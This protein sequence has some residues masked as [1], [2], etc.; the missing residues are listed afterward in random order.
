MTVILATR[1]ATTTAAARSTLVAPSLRS[2]GAT[3]PSKSRQEAWGDEYGRNLPDQYI[4]ITGLTF[5]RYR[6]IP[7]VDASDWFLESNEANNV[8]WI[9]IQLKGE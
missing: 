4:D 9:D 7:T 6:L 1:G 3:G 8:A 5:G 2:E